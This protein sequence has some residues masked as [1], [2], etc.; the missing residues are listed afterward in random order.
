LRSER[1]HRIRGVLA[2]HKNALFSVLRTDTDFAGV[3]ADD[4][5]SG[6]LID[7]STRDND[8]LKSKIIGISL[9]WSVSDSDRVVE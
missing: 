8:A 5:M 9:A 2:Y 1:S 6:T 7:S 4:V 3:I